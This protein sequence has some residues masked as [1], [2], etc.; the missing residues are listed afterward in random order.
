M[1]I[2]DL[3]DGVEEIEK[4]TI[5]GPSAVKEFLKATLQEKI[6]L[7]ATLQERNSDSPSPRKKFRDLFF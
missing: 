5:G 4:K 7:K 2:N 6:F 3:G 1:S